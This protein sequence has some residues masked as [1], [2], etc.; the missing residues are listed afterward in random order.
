VRS[1]RLSYAAFMALAVVDSTAYGI[2]GPIVPAISDATGAGPGVT[3]L[4]VAMFAIGM[5]VGYLLAGVGVHRVGAAPVLAVGVALLATG[6]LGFVLGESL[7]VFF[8]ARFVMGL[9]SG[10]L[11]IGIALGV[12]ERWPGEEYRRVAGAMAMYSAGGVIGPALGAI[13][14][15]GGPFVIYLALACLGG[16]T[17]VF[18]GAAHEKA[19]DFH[20]DRRA[21]RA[22]GFVLAAAGIVMVSVTIGA[23]DG[24][25]PLHFDSLLS[26][27]E[28]AVLYVGTSLVLVFWTFA[29]AR[30]PTRPTLYA[31]TALIV[32]GLSLAGAGTAVWVWIVALALAGT[33]FGLAQASSL[34]V[35]LEAVGTQRIVVAM[36]AWSQAFALGYLLGP[37]LGG[38][39]AE[40]LGFAALGIVPLG[41]ASLVVVGAVSE[42][43]A[44]RATATATMRSR[45]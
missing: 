30:F 42:R 15:I 6:S 2:I 16:L 18:V 45:L 43:R 27:A 9:G 34:G 23:F 7:A 32:A 28:I 29:A 44:Q 26:Q 17:L 1:P 19:P 4:L 12:I 22:P 41:F 24:T 40:T 31:A 8:A 11:W 33:G 38:T 39:V 13:G 14:G 37:A 20:W 5:V 21:L 36:V 35:L 10:G 3:G 25:L